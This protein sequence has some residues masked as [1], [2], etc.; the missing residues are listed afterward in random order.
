MALQAPLVL[1]ITLKRFA[2]AGG[3]H[4]KL[5]RHIA[6]PPTLDLSSL[7]SSAASSPVLY[8]LVAAVVHEGKG[9]KE[10]HT[11]TYAKCRTGVWA[12]FDDAVVSSVNLLT[13]QAASPYVLMY[14]RCPP[15]EGKGVPVFTAPAPVPPSLPLPQATADVRP[16]GTP[17]VLRGVTIS[18]PYV[19]SGTVHISHPLCWPSPCDCVFVLGNRGALTPPP[20]WGRT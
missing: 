13:V 15:R 12:K 1:S 20:E 11:F 3:V 9:G 6:F 10:G 5:S 8:D 16:T 4:S 18:S 17:P 19:L 7:V 14:V 2:F